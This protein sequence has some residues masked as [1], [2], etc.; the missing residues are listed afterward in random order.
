[1][2][3]LLVRRDNKYYEGFCEALEATDQHGVVEQYLQKYR[4]C[5]VVE[6]LTP[7]KCGAAIFVIH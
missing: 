3:A 2:L 5:F 4:V 1:M 6:Q 7:R